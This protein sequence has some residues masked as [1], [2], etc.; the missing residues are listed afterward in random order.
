V[1][2]YIYRNVIKPEVR[3]YNVSE[4]SFITVYV[5]MTTRVNILFITDLSVRTEPL[6][7][8]GLYV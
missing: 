4:T 8:T 2:Q 3:L 1:S 5:E 7:Y 6:L